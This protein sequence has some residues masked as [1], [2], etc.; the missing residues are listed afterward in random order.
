MSESEADPNAT[1]LRL[2]ILLREKQVAWETPR[3]ISILAAAIA[4]V[5]A[6]VVGV[7]SYR[8]GQSS[9]AQRP[10]VVQLAPGLV[11]APAPK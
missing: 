9:A 8:A 3:N 10:I 7:A 5:S 6:A 4:T 1:L 2:D 11:L